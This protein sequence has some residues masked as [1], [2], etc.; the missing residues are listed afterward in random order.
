MGMLGL[1][2]AL[3]VIAD[4]FVATGQMSWATLAERMSHSPARIAGIATRHTTGLDLVGPRAVAVPAR[5][6]CDEAQ[7]PGNGAGEGVPVA[8]VVADAVQEQR[9]G[10]AAWPLPGRER[11][12]GAADLAQGGHGRNVESPA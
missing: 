3:A 11:A 1:E 2:T 10:L 12:G 5:V 8:A 9:G 4:T 7:A 6:G